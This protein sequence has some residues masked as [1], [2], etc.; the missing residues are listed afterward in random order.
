MT[1]TPVR[2]R[3]LFLTPEA[4]AELPSAVAAL[5]AAL[6]EPGRAEGEER[7][8]LESIVVGGGYPEWL[9]YLR[10]RRMLLE[11]YVDRHGED[12]LSRHVADVLMNHWLLAL[13]VDGQEDEAETERSRMAAIVRK[14]GELRRR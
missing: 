6:G 2:D 9:V 3:W 5:A 1:E 10:E 4:E 14:L 13:T 8:A 12:A 7:S 11:R